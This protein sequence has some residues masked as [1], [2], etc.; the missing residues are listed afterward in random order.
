ME[1]NNIMTN[2]GIKRP[3]PSPMDR[4]TW[5]HS[6]LNPKWSREDSEKIYHFWNFCKLS[7]RNEGYVMPII[8]P[9]GRLELWLDYEKGVK[10]FHQ[11]FNGGNTHIDATFRKEFMS[12]DVMKML[13]LK[14]KNITVQDIWAVRPSDMLRYWTDTHKDSR[15]L[16]PEVLWT[17]N[18]FRFPDGEVVG[19]DGGAPEP[20]PGTANT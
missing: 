1:N 3:G 4:A 16:R 13:D 19:P 18:V 17:R 20:I 10:L 9:D 5:S 11:A 15:W 8:T 12:V 7:L 2:T 14:D 6:I